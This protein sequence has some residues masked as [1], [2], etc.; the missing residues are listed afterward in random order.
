VDQSS[1]PLICQTTNGGSIDPNAYVDPVSGGLYLLWKSD[2]N[3]IGLVTHLWG[4]PLA[5][6]GLS[7]AAGT[8]PSLLLTQSEA[9]QAPAIEG[10]TVIYSEGLYYL[11]YGANNFDTAASGIGYATS[12]S[13]LGAYTNRSKA[14]A[15]VDTTGNAQGPQGP[16][17]FVDALGATRVAFA[18]WEGTV[19]YENGG[20][21]SLWIGTLTFRNSD[22]P[23]LS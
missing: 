3:A 16:C 23:L 2:D 13:L 8:S 20:A 19:G 21:R 18:A 6:D 12:E 5:S 22:K 11:L 1:G 9:W 15:W 10:P 7:F 4:E 14:K 17:I